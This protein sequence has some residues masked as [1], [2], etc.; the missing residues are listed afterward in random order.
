M[1]R[2]LLTR[3]HDYYSRAGVGNWVDFYDTEEKAREKA[4]EIESNCESSDYD[5]F[6]I[7]DL[8]NWKDSKVENFQ[9]RYW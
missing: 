1:K 9:K 7:I 8:E 2:Y 3:G 4:K 5:W 6:S